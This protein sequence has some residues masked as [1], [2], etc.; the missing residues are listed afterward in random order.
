[1]GNACAR[2]CSQSHTTD[3]QDHVSMPWQTERSAK[4]L[5]QKYGFNKQVAKDLVAARKTTPEALIELK[6]T[7]QAIKLMGRGLVGEVWMF[8]DLKT[9]DIYAVKLIPRPIPQEFLNSLIREV[10]IQSS[11]SEAQVNLVSVHELLLTSTHL[12]LVEEYAGGGNLTSYIVNQ[13]SHAAS[14]GLFLS[15]DEARYFYKQFIPAVAYCHQHYVA[16]RDLKL[17]NLLL[18]MSDPP[19]IKICDFG[20]AKTWD[21]MH[22]SRESHMAQGTPVYMSPEMIQSN[23]GQGAYDPAEVDVWASGVLLC[24]MLLGF[25]PFDDRTCDAKYRYENEPEDAGDGA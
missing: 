19:R 25:F 14:T 13:Y 9:H 17:D 21:P 18:D 22:L 5:A 7:H 15:E 1:M 24:V 20:F 12:A 8:R 2:A 10:Q 6:G 11:L 23:G 3:S 4:Q 16:H